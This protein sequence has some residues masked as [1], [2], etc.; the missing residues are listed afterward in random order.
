MYFPAICFFCS[1]L[2][3]LPGPVAT[4]PLAQV[5]FRPQ[6]QGLLCASSDHFTGQL[7][8]QHRSFLFLFAAAQLTRMVAQPGNSKEL[9]PPSL[10]HRSWRMSSLPSFL[11]QGTIPEALCIREVLLRRSQQNWAPAE[12][13]KIHPDTGVSSFPAHS[14]FFPPASWD[15]LPHRRYHYL[16][17]GP[18]SQPTL[19]TKTKLSPSLF[20]FIAL[21]SI[22]T[23]IIYF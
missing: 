9:M 5:W 15:L 14:R 2:E 8:T 3:M 6:L 22:F 12:P 1:A 21:H 16:G 4:L 20:I 23:D 10:G 11:L 18:C 19:R 7:Q 13:L 17:A